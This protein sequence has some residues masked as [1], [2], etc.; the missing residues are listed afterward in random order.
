[1]PPQRSGQNDFVFEH[2]PDLYNLPP[3]VLDAEVNLH[4]GFAV[5]RAEPETTD[6]P[7]RR[8]PALVDFDPVGGGLPDHAP[9][10]RAGTCWES[11]NSAAR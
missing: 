2:R 6:E 10:K 1:M 11:G 4:G 9:A 3:E 7:H 5:E 8:T